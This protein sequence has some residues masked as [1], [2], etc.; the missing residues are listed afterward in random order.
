[1]V[2][3]VPERFEAEDLFRAKF[4]EDKVITSRCSDEIDNGF[5]TIKIGR[6]SDRSE[7][8]I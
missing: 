1:M 4:Y 2:F 5:S 8:E 3:A 7:V 6:H